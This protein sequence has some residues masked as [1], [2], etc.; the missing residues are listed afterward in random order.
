MHMIRCFLPNP[1]VAS[2]AVMY[3]TLVPIIFHILMC[4]SMEIIIDYFRL[5]R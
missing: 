5:A 4:P 2:A 1:A 3:L